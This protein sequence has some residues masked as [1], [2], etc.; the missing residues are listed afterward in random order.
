MPSIH[1]SH[2]FRYVNDVDRDAVVDLFHQDAVEAIL[3]TIHNEDFSNDETCAKESDNRS[4][5]SLYMK[6]LQ[7]FLSRVVV[8]FLQDFICQDFVSTCSLPLAAKTI[9]LFV[10]H[11]SLVR[12]LGRAGQAR[13]AS[14]CAQLE[15]VR[16]K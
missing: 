3:L 5:C 12:P 13:L 14:D 2:R 7:G 1:C 4:T 15:M 8:D 16:M 6:E 9:D 10:L 11:A